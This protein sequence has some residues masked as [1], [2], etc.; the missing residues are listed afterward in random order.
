MSQSVWPKDH[1]RESG[2]GSTVDTNRLSLFLICPSR[3]AEIFDGIF[4]LVR[5]ACGVLAAQL[6]VEVDCKRAVDITSAGIIHPEIWRAIRDADL[7]I[8]DI[9]GSNGNVMMELGVAAAWHRKG[10]VVIIRQDESETPR[11][12]DIAPARQIDYRLTPQGIKKLQKQLFAT[13]QE[14]LAASPFTVAAPPHMGLPARVDFRAGNDTGV[15]W[16]PTMAHRRIV[17][18]GFL[19]FGSL[20][21]FRHSWLCAGDTLIRNTR[22][23]ASMK[24]CHPR[25]KAAHLPWIGIMVRSQGYLANYGHLTYLKSDGSVWITIED[26]GGQYHR[27]E[28]IGQLA[29]FDLGSDVFMSFDVSFDEGRWRIQIDEFE[30]E[31]AVADLPYVYNEGR[32]LVQ[33]FFTWVGLRDLAVEC[34]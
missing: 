14:G 17:P 30:W 11:L 20:Y 21:N 25:Q 22:V 5:D 18:E 24:F 13:I 8:A 7:V 9:T 12:F 3:P 23:H 32:V 1:W 27:D 6:G 19:E 2:A 15:L 29:G 34:L 4:E 26:D 16:G 33:G 10:Q 31:R 28:Q